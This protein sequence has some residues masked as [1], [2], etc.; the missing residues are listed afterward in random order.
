MKRSFLQ[1]FVLS[2]LLVLMAALCPRLATA[3]ATAVTPTD[4]IPPG[5][6]EFEMPAARFKVLMPGTPKTSRRKIK[7]DIGEVAATRYTTTDAAN[8]TYDVLLNDYPKAG[9]SKSSPHKL[10]EAVRDGL[11]FQT[12][13]RTTSYKQITLANFPG[14]DLEIMGGEGSHYRVRLVWVET[15][16]YQIMTVTP[17]KPRPEASVFFDSFQITGKP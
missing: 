15:R 4:K 3:A 6:I 17:G 7:T 13:G 2:G 11:V 8:V 9:V 10:L 12:K 1:R 14:R 5:W 16:L